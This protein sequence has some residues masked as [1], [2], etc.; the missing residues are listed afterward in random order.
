MQNAF[1]EHTDLYTQSC[2]FSLQMGLNSE[3]RE[4]YTN[5]PY[6]NHAKTKADTIPDIDKKEIVD[7]A[8][9]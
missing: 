1:R 3:V 5:N 8:E 2:G 9:P 6:N 4:Q 7:F